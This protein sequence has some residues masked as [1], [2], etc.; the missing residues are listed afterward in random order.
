VSN[1]SVNLLGEVTKRTRTLRYLVKITP[2]GSEV[3]ATVGR[4]YATIPHVRLA[5]SGSSVCSSALGVSEADPGYFEGRILDGGKLH[6][7]IDTVNYSLIESGGEFIIDDSDR[8]IG[9]ALTTLARARID[10]YLASPAVGSAD[11]ALIYTGLVKKVEVASPQTWRLAYG[12]SD[13]WMR[14]EFPKNAFTTGAWS[15]LDASVQG[16]PVPIIYGTH[17]ATGVYG[18]TAG[19][20]PAY[21]VDTLGFRWVLA[22][23]YLKTVRRVY[24]NGIVRT[25]TTDYAV[26]AIIV[27]GQ[28]YHTLTLTRF[29]INT[30]TVANPTT[31]NVSAA[32]GLATG[33]VVYI[34]GHAGSTPAIQGVYTVTVTGAATFTIPVNVTVAG[35]GGSFVVVRRVNE[36]SAV[37]RQDRLDV[38]FD[39]DG[40]E[41]K[42]DGS[43]SLIVNPSVAFRHLINNFVAN[44]WTKHVWNGHPTPGVSWFNEQSA[45]MPVNYAYT[46][47]CADFFTAGSEDCSRWI[48]G[49]TR[50]LE[51]G[52]E[53]A[54]FF[55]DRKVSPFWTMGGQLAWLQSD[56]RIQGSAYYATGWSFRESDDVIEG[57]IAQ[58]FDASHRLHRLTTR[59]APTEP[60]ESEKFNEQLD[61]I[62]PTVLSQSTQQRD[63]RWFRSNPGGLIQVLFTASRHLNKTRSV[64]PVMTARMHPRVLDMELYADAQWAWDGGRSS[65]GSVGWGD[66]LYKRK[67]M[68]LV[69]LTLDLNALEVDT[70]WLAL[71]DTLCSYWDLLYLDEAGKSIG[72]VIDGLPILVPGTG[73]SV[74]RSTAKML[75]DASGRGYIQVG[76]NVVPI[77][78]YGL[79]VEAT[80]NSYF[81]RTFFDSGLTGWNSAANGGTCAAVTDDLYVDTALA[82]QSIRIAATGT[83]TG[84]C[85][86]WQQNSLIAGNPNFGAGTQVNVTVI[87]RD[88]A[89]TGGGVTVFIQ[90]TVDNFFWNGTAWAAP[91]VG[92]ATFAHSGG[93]VQRDDINNINVGGNATAIIVYVGLAQ[94]TY[95]A[96]EDHRIFY[97]NLTNNGAGGFTGSPIYCTNA[98]VQRTSDAISRTNDGTQG[99]FLWPPDQGTI[100]V[101][102]MVDWITGEK[103]TNATI[104]QV[105]YDANNYWLI[106]WQAVG[107]QWHFIARSGGVNYDVTVA[108]PANA[109]GSATGRRKWGWIICRFAGPQNEMAD[110]F[111]TTGHALSIAVSNEDGTPSG[112]NIAY[113]TGAGYTAPVYAAGKNVYLGGDQ[114]GVNSNVLCG[115]L[116]RIR[117]MPD[118]KRLSYIQARHKGSMPF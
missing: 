41:D 39:C 82:T 65:D 92:A 76:A 27:N 73:A 117:F 74:A 5:R 104:C 118:F 90:R 15:N 4:L 19:A 55:N 20:L 100:E 89:W 52:G 13:E 113:G 93:A 75:E 110:E 114:G 36:T 54:Q 58:P 35:A 7:A 111:S 11:Y 51:G 18:A 98:S 107:A 37:T 14:V 63:A 25:I 81:I 102:V 49:V 33:D 101:E 23:H 34:T 8:K 77:D 17:D 56:H 106:Q 12:P 53:L 72:N 61:T 28:L 46:Q 1:L 3:D 60:D 57:Q 30:S 97:V 79:Y 43:G 66:V 29:G 70:A 67:L 10:I 105:Y 38:T 94:A 9:A 47:A 68:R 99:K 59:Y 86:I 115:H 91:A 85:F 6:R 103:T 78:R 69:E 50:T 64:Y 88:L 40:I 45:A 48:G 16:K 112:L 87:H 21:W 62:D 80:E 26:G 22:G 31:I 116:R 83:L 24:V 109:P 44:T 96:G 95:V 32:H 108:A 42:G 84:N 2:V 71:E